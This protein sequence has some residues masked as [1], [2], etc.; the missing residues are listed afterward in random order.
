ME[1]YI[2]HMLGKLKTLTDI[3]PTMQTTQ[4]DISVKEFN[5]I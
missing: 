4:T 1:A 5:P 2:R 3:S